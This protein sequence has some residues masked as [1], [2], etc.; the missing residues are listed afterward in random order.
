M[1]QCFSAVLPRWFSNSEALGL[2]HTM[3]IS[4]AITSTSSWYNLSY[5]STPSV[6]SNVSWLAIGPLTSSGETLSEQQTKCMFSSLAFRCRGRPASERYQVPL[7]WEVATCII[8]KQNKGHHD[9]PLSS[10]LCFQMMWSQICCH[11][12]QKEYTY[13]SKL[14]YKF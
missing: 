4:G 3:N 8:S 9:H 10:Y 11:L 6:S 7:L 1:Q 12:L 5:T 2:S 13:R 14:L